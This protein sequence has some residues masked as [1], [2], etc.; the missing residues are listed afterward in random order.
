MNQYLFLFSA[1][2]L[3]ALLGCQPAESISK[4]ALDR[5][6]NGVE[7]SSLEDKPDKI[8]PSVDAGMLADGLERTQQIH[9]RTKPAP[10]PSSLIESNPKRD[11]GN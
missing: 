3:A 10:N 11:P 9:A 1:F 5:Q 7:A 2:L 8:A 6:S 4:S